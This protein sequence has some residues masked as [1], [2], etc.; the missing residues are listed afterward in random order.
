VEE[1]AHHEDRTAC[2]F[3]DRA[4]RV[5]DVGYGA[6]SYIHSRKSGCSCSIDRTLVNLAEPAEQALEQRLLSVC[7]GIVTCRIIHNEY[8]RDTVTIPTRRQA[9][10]HPTRASLAAVGQV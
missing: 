10:Q 9:R 6:S 8:P 1:C 3:T 2:N 5:A 7:G 4:R